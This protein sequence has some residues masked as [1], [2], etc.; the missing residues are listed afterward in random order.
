M[1][2]NERSAFTLI[3]L[4]VV[5][6]II[7]VLIGL[8]LPAVQAAR[9]AAS[10]TKCANNLKQIGLA[11]VSHAQSYRGYPDGGGGW[12]LSRS[13]DATGQPLVSP[14]Q[15]WGWAYQILP[16]IEQKNAWQ[17]PLD[18]TVA[19]TVIPIYFCPSRRAPEAL[20]G[21]QS[22]MPD[23]LRGAIDYA[24]CGGFD[25]RGVDLTNGSFPS[26]GIIV[27]QLIAQQGTVGITDVS[28][29]TSNTV[30]VGE[31]SCNL[32]LMNEAFS[33]PDENNGYIDGWDWDTMRFG[34]SPPISDRRNDFPASLLF[35]SSHPAGCLFV[36]GDGSV[37][38]VH[39]GVDPN[40]FMAVCGRNDK[41]VVNMDGL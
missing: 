22:G 29:G 36:L 1:K 40:L 2:R 25:G 20:L 9:E 8:L 21:C 12:W 6:A 15:A 10:R 24:G 32:N 41:L 33:T 30:M 28:D 37:R 3:E 39:Y 23:G 14:H 11:C 16:F 19:A 26:N 7:A 5:I 17:A 38:M 18:T 35:G 34:N 27:S 31:R 4:L 13:K